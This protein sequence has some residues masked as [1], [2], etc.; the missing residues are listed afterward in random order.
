MQLTRFSSSTACA[1]EAT[2]TGGFGTL[3]FTKTCLVA[4]SGLGIGL[5]VGEMLAHV[6][7]LCCCNTVYE[8]NINHE[9]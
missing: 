7:G 4:D 6:A 3:K 9:L 1:G 8:H 5:G 2:T